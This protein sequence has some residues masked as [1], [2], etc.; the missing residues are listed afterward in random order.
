MQEQQQVASDV[1]VPDCPGCRTK[2]EATKVA[3]WCS[4]CGYRML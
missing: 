1:E 4:G 3:W 2:M